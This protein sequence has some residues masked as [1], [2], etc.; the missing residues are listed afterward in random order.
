MAA[1]Q[2]QPTVI[3]D[4]DVEY[5]AVAEDDDSI[6]NPQ[7]LCERKQECL[8]PMCGPKSHSCQ[9]FRIYQIFVMCQSLSC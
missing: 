3:I 1:C 8:M 7:L 6:S 5:V 4:S 9:F 2:G